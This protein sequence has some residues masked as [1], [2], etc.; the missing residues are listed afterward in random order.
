[1]AVKPTIPA[2]LWLSKFL[3]VRVR[4]R[5]RARAW[6]MNTVVH[7]DVRMCGGPSGVPVTPDRYRS[8]VV[9]SRSSDD[10]W[11]ALHE[12]R[13][14]TG[15]GRGSAG[16]GKLVDP[17]WGRVVTTRGRKWTWTWTRT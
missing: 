11:C 8:G 1:V 10:V 17:W 14:E 2:L 4:A 16:V 7:G 3:R 15:Q 13:D 12:T 5:V 9:C 6:D